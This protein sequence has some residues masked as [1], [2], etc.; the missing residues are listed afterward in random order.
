MS[1][2]ASPSPRSVLCCHPF[3]PGVSCAASP[4][5]PECPVLPALPPPGVS[6]AASPS[7]RSVLCCQ[8]FPPGVSCVAS[9]SPPECPVLL[10]LP[11]GRLLKRKKLN[12]FADY[13]SIRGRI[14]NQLWTTSFPVA[15]TIK[16]GKALGMRFNFWKTALDPS[17]CIYKYSLKCF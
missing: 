4:S 5:P 3:P 13:G 6:C 8:P 1:C 12:P 15:H 16:K 17:L 9:P 2:V 11:Y 10:A 14:V 7:P